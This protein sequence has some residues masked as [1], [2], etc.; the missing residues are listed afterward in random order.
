MHGIS[1]LSIFKP[2]IYFLPKPTCLRKWEC[3]LK[4]D[5]LSFPKNFN[6]A[7][8]DN[9][10]LVAPLYIL[11]LIV[12]HD[13]NKV[14][15]SRKG[16]WLVSMVKWFFLFCNLYCPRFILCFH[17]LLDKYNANPTYVRSPCK[18]VNTHTH[19]HAF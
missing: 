19:V 17:F 2:P 9:S 5:T 6:H 8:V 18:Q 3:M 12:F 13:N 16:G 14:L 1:K 11:L 4:I 7:V 15:K 10:N